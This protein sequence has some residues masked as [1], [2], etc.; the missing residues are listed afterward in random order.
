YLSIVIDSDKKSPQARLNETKRRVQESFD[1]DAADGFAWITEGYTIENYVP[2]E[3]LE[4]AVGEVHPRATQEWNGGKWQN[5]LTLKSRSGAS[6]SPDKNRIARVVCEK[7]V[8]PPAPKTHLG[9]MI[10][11]CVSFIHE[12][13]RTSASPVK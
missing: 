4:E 8:D 1:K 10:K 12:A 6:Q 5:P 7:W 9:R 3:I 2:R 11:K 13:N